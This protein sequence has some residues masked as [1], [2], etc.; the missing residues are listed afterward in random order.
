VPKFSS[1]VLLQF[2]LVSFFAGLGAKPQLPVPMHDQTELSVAV[3]AAS[4]EYGRVC[5][6]N[7]RAVDALGLEFPATLLWSRPVM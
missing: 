6:Q 2:V 1:A 5:L 4:H 7:V 3:S